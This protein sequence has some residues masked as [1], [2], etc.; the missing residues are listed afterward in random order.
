FDPPDVNSG[1]YRFEPAP[2]RAG[3]KLIR[4]GLG[5]VK[6]TGQGAIEAIVAAREGQTEASPVAGP[7]RSLFDFA[8]RVDRTRVNKRVVEGLG[9]EKTAIGFFLSGHLFDENEAEVRQFCKRRIADLIDSREPQ[10]LAGIVSD[11]RVING[12][13][14]RVAIFK[15]DDK[16]DAIEAVANEEL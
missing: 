10:V 3:D 1:V 14:G 13:R 9:L 8:K 5:A 15:L 2:G 11:L 7:F 12:Q 6:G 16:S 4:Y